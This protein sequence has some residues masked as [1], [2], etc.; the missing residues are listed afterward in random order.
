MTIGPYQKIVSMNTLNIVSALTSNTKDNKNHVP[1]RLMHRYTKEFVEQIA[2]IKGMTDQKDWRKLSVT[3]RLAVKKMNAIIATNF[4]QIV[5]RMINPAIFVS[6]ISSI[7]TEEEAN[8]IAE[9]SIDILVDGLD[10]TGHELVLNDKTLNLKTFI[11]DKIDDK[12]DSDDDGFD[13]KI[14]DNIDSDDDGFDDDSCG[15]SDESSDC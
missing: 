3:D 4:P 8:E 9:R 2:V 14:D 10:S 15:S 7:I 5:R 11:D 12:I 13:N 6:L 1:N